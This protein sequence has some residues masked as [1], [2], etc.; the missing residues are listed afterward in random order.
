MTT[1][2]TQIKIAI[3]GGGSLGHVTS[4]YLAS[5]PGVTVAMLTRHPHRWASTLEI[6]DI[7]GKVFN[8]P[9]SVVSDNPAEVL[10]G[11]QIVLLCLPGYAIERT[12]ETIKPFIEPQ[13]LVGS[14]VSST[15]FFFTAHRTLE[16][17]TRLFGFQ[18]V[19]FIARTGEYGHSANLLGYKQGLNVAVEGVDANEKSQFVE[20][21]SYLFDLPVKLLGSH[22]EASLTNSNPLLHPARLYSLLH[23]WHSG[24]TAEQCPYFYREWDDMA[25]QCYIDMDKEFQRLLTLLPVT[26]GSIPDVLT[27]Y[28]SRDAR[29]LTRKLRSIEAFKNIK[30]PYLQTTDGTFVP[31]FNSRYF[32][33][34]FPFGIRFIVEVAHA[35]HQEIPVIEKIY[36]WGMQQIMQHGHQQ[37]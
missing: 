19:P 14:I 30:A 3:C 15:G 4:G 7:N 8:G 26:S 28:E 18:R 31:D 17:G 33:E 32:T 24:D 16:A 25:S 35:H 37:S 29:S 11:A 21:L 23:D 10:R 36:R 13:T 6:T 20:L 22:Y 5:K 34:D 1:T 12:L 9:L 2:S 27:Y